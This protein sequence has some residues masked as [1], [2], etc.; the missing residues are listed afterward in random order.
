[1]DQWLNETLD[2][3]NLGAHGITTSRAIEPGLRV[4]ADPEALKQVVANLAQNAVKYA[5]GAAQRWTAIRESGMAVIR[6]EDAGPGIPP[7]DLPHVFERFYRGGKARERDNGG[8]GLGLAIARSI[9]EAHGGRI[10]ASTASGGGAVFT[11]RL[12]LAQ[13]A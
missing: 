4:E 13:G 9:V 10:E 2:E 12:P 1:V 7:E 6:V 11:V 5:P 8:S 3:L